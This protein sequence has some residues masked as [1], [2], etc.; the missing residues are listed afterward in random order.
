MSLGVSS[1]G[2]CPHVRVPGFTSFLRPVL[3]VIKKFWGK[4]RK[5]EFPPKFKNAQKILSLL[6]FH[7]L[8]L[9]TFD[10]L[11]LHRNVNFAIQLSFWP[12]FETVILG[13]ISPSRFPLFLNILFIH[14]HKFSFYRHLNNVFH[15]KVF[16]TIL[17]ISCSRVIF[18]ASFRSIHDRRLR[19]NSSHRCLTISGLQWKS[20]RNLFEFQLF[21]LFQQC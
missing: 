15:M 12:I 19:G 17:L 4:F 6:F 10:E 13:E 20:Y 1:L 7:F 16:L 14:V 2:A 3:N 11:A 18:P 5:S 8:F 9:L 21:N